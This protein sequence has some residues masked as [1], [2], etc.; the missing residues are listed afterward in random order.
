MKVDGVLAGDN[1]GDGRAGL[2]GRRRRLLGGLGVVFRHCDGG[3]F[4][5]V[6]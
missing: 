5:K 3:L 2:L 6:C 1:I 4:D